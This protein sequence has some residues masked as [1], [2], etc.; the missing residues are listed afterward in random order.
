[1]I[2]RVKVAPSVLSADFTCL[3]EDVLS[4]Q[5]AGADELHMDVMDGHFVPNISFGPVV[6]KAVRE[7][8]SLPLSAHLMISNPDRYL[9]DYIESG[10]SAI[11]F[12]IEAKGD[13]DAIINRLKEN[14]VKA[15]LV[16]NPDT[17]F[18]SIR[19]YID[20]VDFV[21]VMSVY[22]GF[23]GQEFIPD[24]L[25]KIRKI[26]EERGDIEISVDGG[27]NDKTAPRVRKAG[28]STLVSA[29]YIFSSQDRRKAIDVLRG[30]SD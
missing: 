12:H 5:E 3:R 19:K 22:P 9:E 21:L 6:I 16:L 4:V 28:G 30:N 7:I 23:S 29:S 24:V 8:S 15:G 13:P 10:C 17:P 20:A 14:E 27:I 11:S 18:K 1:M 25:P 26:R 2:K